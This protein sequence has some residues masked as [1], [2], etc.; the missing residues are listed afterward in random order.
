MANN[1][2]I[3]TG[4]PVLDGF[5]ARTKPKS[6]GQQ[7]K[8][9]LG[10]LGVAAL[11][12]GLGIG[13]SVVGLGN[14]V[15]GG[16]IGDAAK[17]AGYDSARTNDF[18]NSLHSDDYLKGQQAVQQ[19]GE[20]DGS[21]WDR[22][23][24]T[25]GALI[26]NPM[27][28]AG[29][30]AESVPLMLPGMGLQSK[31][32]KGMTAGLEGAA[33]EQAIKAAMPKMIAAG[34][35][36][37]GVQQAGSLA[38]Q[39]QNAG[40]DWGDYVAPAVASGVVDAAIAGGSGTLLGDVASKMLAGK[41]IGTGGL[42]GRFLKGAATEG[43][44]E[45]LPQSMQE[46][47]AQNVAM[48]EPDRW[49]GVGAAGVQG[50]VA[51]GLMGGFMNLGPLAKAAQKS[52]VDVPT[53][54]QTYHQQLQADL[55]N[56]PEQNTDANSVYQRQEEINT[57]NEA[58][59]QREQLPQIEQSQT[60]YY[61]GLRSGLLPNQEANK[62]LVRKAAGVGDAIAQSNS[63]NAEKVRAKILLSQHKKGFVDKY[64]GEF[65]RQE[66]I[67]SLDEM[68]ESNPAKVINMINNYVS[69]ENTTTN[70]KEQYHPGIKT[71]ADEILVNG[72]SATIKD[73]NGAIIHRTPSVNPDWFKNGKFIVYKDN[74]EQFI[75][76]ASVKKI[77][78]TVDKYYEG[79]Q[80]LN[81]F[82]K[83][84]LSTLNNIALDREAEV[85][86]KSIEN[87][88]ELQDEPAL[89]QA[90]TATQ[91]PQQTAAE[92]SNNL[93][94][95]N[96]SN[97]ITNNEPTTE[98]QKI[99]TE[100]SSTLAEI[101]ANNQQPATQTNKAKTS[102]AAT[103]TSSSELGTFREYHNT[104]TEKALPQVKDAQES[105]NYDDYV[106]DLARDVDSG[107]SLTD[108]LLFDENTPVYV[109]TPEEYAQL[110][111]TSSAKE[112]Y[113][114]AVKMAISE[115][116]LVPKKV[117]EAVQRVEE[118]KKE[119]SKPQAAP[120]AE[121]ANQENQVDKKKL[122]TE[123]A[124]IE[125]TT[126]KGKILRGIVRTDLNQTQAKAIDPYTF[127]KDGGYFI[128]EK[129]LDGYTATETIEP[130]KKQT[131]PKVEKSDVTKERQ[132]KSANRLRTIANKAIE[133]A[134]EELNRDRQTNTPKRAREAGYADDKA[135]VQ[136]AL[137]K[138]ALNIA[139][140]IESGEAVLLANLSSMTQVEM[141]NNVRNTALVEYPNYHIEDERKHRLYNQLSD[142]R[143]GKT[144]YNEIASKYYLQREH[145]DKVVKL[146]GESDAK[147]YVGWRASEVFKEQERLK[148]LGITDTEQFKNALFEFSKF[149]ADRQKEDPVKAAERA[150]VGKKVGLD[151]FPTPVAIAQRMAQLAEIEPGMRVLEPS[152]GNGNLADAAKSAGAKVDVIE[153]SN[154]LRNVLEAK[155]Y[156]I[157]AHDFMEFSPSELY[158]AVIMN[159]PF[160]NRLDADHIQ[161]AFD[162]VKP[163]G[164]LV[165][166]AGEGVFFGSD[167]KAL[168]FR[169]WLDE[170]TAEVEKLDSGTFQDKSLLATTGA[171]ARLIVMD[172]PQETKFSKSPQPQTTHTATSLKSAMAK[173]F[174]QGW[175]DRLLATNKVKVINRAD[176][177]S[178]LGDGAL[179]HK[180]WHGSPH[181]HNKF[182][183]SKI[184]TGE[185]A[186]AFGYGHY[187]TDSKRIA[188][189]YR[190]KLSGKRSASF[191]GIKINPGIYGNKALY[192]YL[193][194]DLA[195]DRRYQGIGVGLKPIF[196]AV[197]LGED[198][199]NSARRDALESL[200]YDKT[201]K[202][203][204]YL[205]EQEFYERQIDF[206]ENLDFNK[207]FEWDS[208]K[209]YETELAPAQEEYLD[210]DKPLSEQSD[211]V[212]QRLIN[213]TDKTGE[214]LYK[215]LKKVAN[216]KRAS[217]VLSKLG[218][219]GIRYKAEGGKS[220][221]NNYVIFDDNDIQIVAK[222]SKNGNIQAFY[223]PS[224]DTAYFVHDN[225]SKDTDIKKL[226]LH[227]LGVHALQLGRNDTEFKAILKRIDDLA[228]TSNNKFIKAAVQ[229][230]TAANTP[231]HLM[232]EEILGYLVEKHPKLSIAQ[233]FIQWFKSKIRSVF[234]I[235]PDKLTEADLVAMATE[236]L[237]SAPESLVFDGDVKGGKRKS[238]AGQKAVNANKSALARAVEMEQQGIDK[239][240][241]RKET[242]W[243]L[244]MDDK[245]RFEI[246]DS[247]VSFKQSAIQS[248][249][250]R[251]DL[252]P[253]IWLDSMDFS[254]NDI[255]MEVELRKVLN[256]PKLFEAYPFLKT[257]KLSTVDGRGGSYRLSELG[258]VI[259]VGDDSDI[260]EKLSTLLHEIQHAIQTVEGFATGGNSVEF[261][262][263]LSDNS[264]N[265]H[266]KALSEYEDAVKIKTLMLKDNNFSSVPFAANE[267]EARIGRAVEN[268]AK[269]LARQ[270]DLEALKATRQEIRDAI[271]SS[272]STNQAFDSYQRL[273]GEIES[274]D[275]QSRMNM[276]PAQRIESEPYASQGI[277]KEDAIIR[278][279]NGV[280][281]SRNEPVTLQIFKGLDSR[282]PKATREKTMS[283][284]M[285]N[286]NKDRIMYIND[287]FID[288]LSQLEDVKGFIIKC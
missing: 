42:A 30:V 255:V 263:G 146:L 16:L 269:S 260:K 172:K 123:N 86:S 191:N 69:S 229:A 24:N 137:A 280:A 77:K 114:K 131:E 171:N 159:P 34:A 20:I 148:R 59:K 71:L 33:K 99:S 119:K 160:S 210:W 58:I 38:D 176:I 68:V 202:T 18:I 150:L 51:G 277:A 154:D 274:R 53:K 1:E 79:K 65:P 117:V 112:T 83:G 87:T 130:E 208:G 101:P 4:D 126:T 203:R 220:D 100:Q 67:S 129:Y 162:M 244:G 76:T 167:K 262:K 174:G 145:Y 283:D 120:V 192:D 105:K 257:V 188:E 25:L 168:A 85:K 185:G 50:L 135:R 253:N 103:S 169:E 200:N 228:K 108:A 183:S 5:Y 92:Q 270:Y 221:A 287:N 214:Q 186:Q 94:N 141:L 272:T 102:P 75:Q 250:G 179:F 206:L 180:V 158:D 47:Y 196:D 28:A 237:R 107:K 234:G 187:F 7:I 189:W 82:E 143:G 223:N 213:A 89:N 152:A 22:G 261:K 240:T 279:G 127:K 193:E 254:S 211:F 165:A 98:P 9:G 56:R 91:E 46:Q 163:G 80:A 153:I 60:D 116:K 14:I 227:E 17:Y 217:E 54:D 6:A 219:R 73:K 49:K 252:N 74:G 212:K 247:D 45:E 61:T 215:S 264:I 164:K 124:I 81:N 226:M 19:A 128:R 39:S 31:I 132:L 249:G 246:D 52:G 106:D 251:D 241:I 122:S 96:N 258:S 235:N 40:R 32:Y 118:S 138:T 184:G 12:G 175:F 93:E 10:D 285:D 140:A 157:V 286:P 139:D 268:G 190:N 201:N 209:L 26:A 232:S 182:D 155:G 136:I 125:H 256:A 275:V 195:I 242:G 197:N 166:I 113:A 78:E 218:I 205:R 21:E 194:D 23:R 276:T 63:L 11:K 266:K 178:V 13:Q 44:T 95:P 151:Y 224:D 64:S 259:S 110:D 115:G 281:E 27:Q 204:R 173:V 35:G 62:G 282:S 156:P 15:S 57:A 273:A 133:K 267:I 66:L 90:P 278:F 236:A 181:D 271:A 43:F 239:Q 55:A 225:I 288:I 231:E 37:E 207:G 245:W 222:Y 149:K 70:Q 198:A 2:V 48:G 134:E 97:E 144:L 72:D 41:N 238:Y 142:K 233:R 265:D 170:N 199:F 177:D 248:F 121:Q 29:S 230:A 3:E 109:M 8:Q 284:I 104:K 36:M 161:H 216:Q 147:V 84:I 243:F 111:T 88:T